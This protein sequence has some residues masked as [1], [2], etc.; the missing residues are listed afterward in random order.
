MMARR[1]VNTA[2]VMQVLKDKVWQMT[3]NSKLVQDGKS[4]KEKE[5]IRTKPTTQTSAGC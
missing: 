5:G 2:F 3:D 4:T 1:E